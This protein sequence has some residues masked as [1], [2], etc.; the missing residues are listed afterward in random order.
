[1]SIE[2]FS[3]IEFVCHGD[4][5]R[6]PTVTCRSDFDYWG[7]QFSR[8]GHFMLKVNDNIEYTRDACVFV[9]APGM[10]FVYGA[11]DPAEGIEDKIYI[12]FKGDRVQRYLAGG[13]LIERSTNVLIHLNEPD[14][15]MRKMR[16]IRTLLMLPYSP[17]NHAR[18]VLAL[19]E[20]LLMMQAADTSGVHRAD[21]RFQAFSHLTEKISSRP[22]LHW[23][24]EKEARKLSVS[25]AHFRR[26]FEQ[27]FQVPPGAFLL[28]ARLEKAAALLS[29]TA[30]QI[31]E[32]AHECGF[33]DEFYFSRIFK[34]YRKSSPKA[35][36]ENAR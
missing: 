35:Y 36:R 18:A 24:F 11:A 34:K 15:F 10:S 28:A 22:E 1:M 6:S 12:C 19:E 8:R 3:D 4:L 5:R 20:L 23:D 16:S 13:L 7:L 21:E 17:E 31:R 27:F 26:L 33:E 2:Y 29:G 32:I 9:T 30:L 25:Y 14:K